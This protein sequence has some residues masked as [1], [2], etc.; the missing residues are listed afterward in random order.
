MSGKLKFSIATPRGRRWRSNLMDREGR[1]SKAPPSSLREWTKAARFASLEAARVAQDPKINAYIW[2]KLDACQALGQSTIPAGSAAPRHLHH[3][4]PLPVHGGH[5]CHA[6]DKGGTFLQSGLRRHSS[7]H[8][9]LLRTRRRLSEIVGCSSSKFKNS[10][11]RA[12]ASSCPSP[13]RR[14]CS[15]GQEQIGT[16]STQL[17]TSC[18]CVCHQMRLARIQSVGDNGAPAGAQETMGL[19]H[20]ELVQGFSRATWPYQAV[21]ASQLRPRMDE[22]AVQVRSFLKWLRAPDAEPTAQC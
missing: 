16:L 3:G 8:M 22:L 10:A 5:V 17:S 2:V 20:N 19:T 4:Q 13:R 1:S 11:S 12:C 18:R 6:A 15:L 9:H 14:A 7:L 21:F